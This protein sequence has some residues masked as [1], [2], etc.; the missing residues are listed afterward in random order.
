MDRL[1]T[2]QSGHRKSVVIFVALLSII[3]AITFADKA[4]D[5]YKALDV[6]LNVATG[7]DVLDFKELDEAIAA[8]EAEI[9]NLEV[10]SAKLSQRILKRTKIYE[11]A[12]KEYENAQSDL[13]AVNEKI[14][15]A[16]SDYN[17]A[18]YWEDFYL[19]K[20]M[21]HTASCD[22]C[23]GSQMCSEGS[24]LHSSWQSWV[25]KRKTA[26]R[27]WDNAK[28]EFMPAYDKWFRYWRSYRY[29]KRALGQLEGEFIATT[30]SI[31]N[32]NKE[33]TAKRE[34]KERLK[35]LHDN[36]PTI[37]SYMLSLMI[38]RRQPDFDF[39]KWIEANPIPEV[40]SED[41]SY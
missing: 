31:S 23:R 36:I 34:E 12:K 37:Q 28:K 19:T 32:K 8:L 14:A 39:D 25:K 41:V 38:A 5:L 26:K 35:R 13:D 33:L 40:I 22:Y 10:S 7:I 11:L 3:V 17:K 29:W 2:Q 30:I 9:Q 16:K 6:T 27:A 21:N 4:D 20:Y 1:R 15:S 18:T 24:S